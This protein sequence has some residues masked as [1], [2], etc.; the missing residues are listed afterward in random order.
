MTLAQQCSTPWFFNKIANGIADSTIPIPTLEIINRKV[1]SRLILGQDTNRLDRRE[2]RE[3][4]FGEDMKHVML[5]RL[6][7]VEES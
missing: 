6:F 4:L 7:M 1:P 2:L 3:F 5:R